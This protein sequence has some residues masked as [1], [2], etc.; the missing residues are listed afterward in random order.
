M[1]KYIYTWISFHGITDIL[2]PLNIWAPVYGLSLLSNA[3]PM[4]YLNMITFILSGVHFYYDMY[5]NLVYI[6]SILATLLYF[7][8]TKY[9]QLIILSYMSLIHVPIHLYNLEWSYYTYLSLISC[10]IGFYNC[11]FLINI[12]DKII[13]SGAT[14]P[15]NHFHKT[16]LGFIN[17]HII[18]NLIDIN[19]KL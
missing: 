3:L 4:N 9:S 14:L 11:D 7:G 10:Y 19:T 16:L 8:K 17:A 18:T 6:Y 2:L 15:N 12:L 1:I 5:L 13:S